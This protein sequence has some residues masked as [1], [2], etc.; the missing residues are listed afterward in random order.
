MN[1]TTTELDRASIADRL[2]TLEAERDCKELLARYG[3]YA[4]HGL[5]AEWVDLF[6]DDGIMD[7]TFFD[8]SDYFDE[9]MRPRTTDPTTLDL[10]LRNVRFVGRTQLQD[11]IR[12]DRHERFAGKA[13]HHMDGQPSVFVQHDEDHAVI[14]SNSIV[15]CRSVGSTAPSIQYQNH[16]VNRWSFRRVDGHWRIAENVRRV[17]GSGDVADILSSLPPLPGSSA[18]A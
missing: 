13:Q 16:C 15:Y 18:T 7:F 11:C 5:Y 1:A 8:D 2:A 10:P 3:L 9:K 12:A 4:D 14:I 6:T 17:M